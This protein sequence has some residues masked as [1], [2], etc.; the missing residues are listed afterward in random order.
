MT[1]STSISSRDAQITGES[2]HL[3]SQECPL[4]SMQIAESVP[5]PEVIA[6]V[7][8]FSPHEAEG[9]PSI[10][11]R[12]QASRAKYTRPIEDVEQEI[13][14]WR[15]WLCSKSLMRCCFSAGLPIASPLLTAAK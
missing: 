14:K 7:E 1:M 11:V 2:F 12:E 6:E 13:R 10:F 4:P 15:T 9:I 5:A 8:R 3:E